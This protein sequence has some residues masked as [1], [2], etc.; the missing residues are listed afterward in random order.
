M[1]VRSERDRGRPAR[2][3][4]DRPEPGERVLHRSIGT[5]PAR[6]RHGLGTQQQADGIQRLRLRHLSTVT[7][8]PPL[9]EAREAALEILDGEIGGLVNNAG[10]AQAGALEDV[11]RE[12]LRYQFEVNV[13]GL[14]ELTN[15][16]IPVFRNQG[17]G[18]IVNVSSAYG[19]VTAP[20]LGSYC[21]TKYAVESLSDAMRMELRRSGIAVSLVEPGP[22]VTAFRRNAADQAARSL[23]V[24][25]SRFGK[26]YARLIDRRRKQEKKPDLF[27][28]PPEAVAV[29]IRHAL[30]AP[31]PKAR[32][33][34]TIP[35]HLAAFGRRFFPTALIDR[36]LGGKGEEEGT[37]G[38]RDPGTKG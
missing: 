13:F 33:L 20:M 2:R 9:R 24:D 18:R 27:T 35:A 19:L 16:F 5:G 8:A 31:R 12:A 32:Y 37:Q 25:A 4:Q 3:G 26:T 14:Q 10:F 6:G 17:A 7:S 30:E 36:L 28:R 34:V 38:P 23:D 29:K 22:I 15:C 11:S 1:H 21:A